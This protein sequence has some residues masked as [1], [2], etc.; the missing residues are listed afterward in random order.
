MA[1]PS[2]QL[3]GILAATHARLDEMFEGYVLLAIVPQLDGD[4]EVPVTICNTGTAKTRLAL[5]SMAAHFIEG[6]R[7]EPTPQEGDDAQ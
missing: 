5:E 3:D 2:K 7:Y 4:E 1:I 6:Q